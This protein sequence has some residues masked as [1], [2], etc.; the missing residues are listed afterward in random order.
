LQI[1]DYGANVDT[2]GSSKDGYK[3][4]AQ[5]RTMLDDWV[6]DQTGGGGDDPNSISTAPG[7]ASDGNLYHRHKFDSQGD[8]NTSE[9]EWWNHRV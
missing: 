4:L 6:S 2:D 5:A 8:I 9:S 7:K 3:K 1:S